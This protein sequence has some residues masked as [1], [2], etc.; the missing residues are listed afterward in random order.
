MEH[1]K[2]SLRSYTSGWHTL[3]SYLGWAIKYVEVG[4]QIHL[5]PAGIMGNNQ[6]DLYGLATGRALRGAPVKSKAARVRSPPVKMQNCLIASDLLG[7]ICSILGFDDD[8]KKHS[9]ATLF[10]R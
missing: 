5:Y 9:P 4:R 1:E 2:A 3:H 8:A 7:S 10:L 6:R